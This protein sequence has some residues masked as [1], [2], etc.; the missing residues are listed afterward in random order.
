MDIPSPIEDVKITL[1]YK[2][3]RYH[4]TAAGCFSLPAFESMCDGTRSPPL[5][6]KDHNTR[7]KGAPIPLQNGL[8]VPR[9]SASF[10]HVKPLVRHSCNGTNHLH[11][12]E[13]SNIGLDDGIVIQPDCPWCSWQV[14]MEIEASKGLLDVGYRPLLSIAERKRGPA[15]LVQKD[16]GLLGTVSQLSL[17]ALY[18][19]L[20]ARHI[21]L[22]DYQVDHAT[23]RLLEVST[24]RGH[25]CQQANKSP[26]VTRVNHV[27]GIQA[28]G[29][30][31]QASW[32][33]VGAINDVAA[34]VPLIA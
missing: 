13:R 19:L 30:C 20:G 4:I 6:V 29:L 11:L 14:V 12:V 26:A 34:K 24:K 15:Q 2:I 9:L 23:G 18:Q 1:E 22:R 16:T 17:K 27:H 3:Q 28:G 7:V 8:K 25:A 5:E 10:V 21:A 31:C 33:R 32:R